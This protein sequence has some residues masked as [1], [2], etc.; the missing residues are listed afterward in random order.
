[1]LLIWVDSTRNPFEN[2]WLKEFS[3]VDTNDLRVL[4]LSSY[5]AL[6]DFILSRGLP[7]AICLDDIF[8]DQTTGEDCVRFLIRYCKDNKCLPPAMGYQS[9]NTGK[10]AEMQY[11]INN[12]IISFL[13]QE[14]LN[15]LPF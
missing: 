10:V 3:P 7:D 13:K 2:G 1:M 9:N 15:T 12:Y 14:D 11:I 8:E 5:K 6:K 4:W